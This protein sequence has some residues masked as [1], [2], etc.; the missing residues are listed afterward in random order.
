MHTSRPREPAPTLSTSVRKRGTR[1]NIED[2]VRMCNRRQ[3]SDVKMLFWSLSERYRGNKYARSFVEFYFIFSF[4][5]II[6]A[7]AVSF[8][9]KYDSNIFKFWNIKVFVIASAYIIN[10]R[11]SIIT[12]SAI[13]SLFDIVC[14][15]TFAF[16]TFLILFFYLYF[17]ILI[18]A[19]Q[20][21]HPPSRE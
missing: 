11:C 6:L 18:Q 20:I 16:Y 2:K 21:T 1:W 5:M 4:S 17:L 7:S 10:Q 14:I 12:S 3:I 13:E 19:M 15:S 8:I 9:F